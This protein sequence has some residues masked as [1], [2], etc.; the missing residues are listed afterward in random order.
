MKQ[1]KKYGSEESPNEEISKWSH[2]F[3]EGPKLEEHKLEAVDKQS[4]MTEIKRLMEMKVLKPIGQEQAKSGS[5]KHLSTKIDYNWSHRDGQWKRSVKLLSALFALSD[6]YI[7]G[8]VKV[9]DA[10]LQVEKQNRQW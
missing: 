9:S 10:Y 1:S 7:L 6:G 3:E 8:S 5:Y 2:E 4:R